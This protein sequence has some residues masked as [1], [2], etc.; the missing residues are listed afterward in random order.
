M[1][2]FDV[3]LPTAGIQ[4]LFDRFGHGQNILLDRFEHG[5]N[6]EGFDIDFFLLLSL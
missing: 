1:Y 6:E 2:S 4:I 3:D 5:Q